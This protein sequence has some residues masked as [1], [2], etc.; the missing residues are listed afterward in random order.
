MILVDSHCHID[1]PEL[2]EDLDGVLERAKA[3]GVSYLLCVAVN[4]EDLENIKQISH[5]YAH[6]FA[7]AGVH[8]NHDPG[9]LDSP[10]YLELRE[11][12]ADPIV[13]AVGETG[14][15]YYRSKGD[16]KWQSD[17]F[18]KHI[19][20]SRELGKPLVVH[21]RGANEDTISIMREENA[22]EAGGVMHCFSEDW[23]TAKAALDMGFY[24][25]ISGIVT[26]KNADSVREVARKVPDDRLLVETDA[27]Y[28]APV[29][30]RGRTNEP[31]FVADTAS[32][33][34]ELRGVEL[35]L[36]AQQ[37][38]DNFFQLFPLATRQNH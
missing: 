3:V 30:H 10:E 24:V 32:F 12:A 8:P 35:D 6:V 22:S 2:S 5:R 1:F 28:L 7:T 27:P 26:F 34:A 33:L 14:L 19:T 21:T 23:A 29:P 20:V 38:T 13:V 17:R 25:S 18:R 9:I 31:A 36:L 4:L 11:A 37:T 15:D 16:L